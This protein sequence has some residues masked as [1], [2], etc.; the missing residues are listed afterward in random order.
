MLAPL[1]AA[2]GLLLHQS[3]VQPFERSR[4][5]ICN[6]TALIAHPSTGKTPACNVIKDSLIK[7]ESYKRVPPDCSFLTNSGSVEGL[8]EHLNNIPC[9]V[10][11]YDE[12]NTFLGQLARYGGGNNAALYE[13]SIYLSLFSAVS[14]LDRDLKSDRTKIKN[15]RFHMCLLGHPFFFINLSLS[16]IF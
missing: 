12:S 5:G 16:L 14:S 15:P 4:Q 2:L 6:F 3:T 8:L 9:M 11:F 7:L 1:L 10:A 13:R